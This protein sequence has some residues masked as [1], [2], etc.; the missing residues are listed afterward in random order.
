MSKPQS[1]LYTL[2]PAV[3]RKIES[4]LRKCNFSIYWC[5][6]LQGQLLKRDFALGLG[7]FFRNQV[8]ISMTN[9][10]LVIPVITLLCEA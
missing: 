3:L 1:G 5:S 10:T 9:F 7:R 2:R 6:H 8:V 4:V